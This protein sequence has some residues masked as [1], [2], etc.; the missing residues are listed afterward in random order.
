MIIHI[1]SSFTTI[2]PVVMAVNGHQ[3]APISRSGYP[4][5][6]TLLRTYPESLPEVHPV[7]RGVTGTPSSRCVSARAAA[8]GHL[9]QHLEQFSP[10]TMQRGRLHSRLPAA[11]TSQPI[12]RV[13]I[14]HIHQSAPTTP[15]TPHPVTTH[16]G[17]FRNR[18][19]LRPQSRLLRPSASVRHPR[20]QAS[21]DCRSSSSKRLETATRT[22]RSSGM[23]T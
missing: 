9:F 16:Q 1:N 15:Q 4:H 18:S 20:F 23:A 14:G 13:N 7:A 3:S 12:A 17:S 11:S 5:F 21:S 2:R 22:E 8:S 19:N 10:S 6:Q